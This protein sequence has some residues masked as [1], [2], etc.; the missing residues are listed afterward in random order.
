MTA[1][2]R[3]PPALAACI[4]ALLCLARPAPAQIVIEGRVLD[5]MTE[6]VLAGARVLLL[7][8]FNR[9]A[10]YAVTDA[11]GRFRFERS[12]NERYR[13]E[14]RAVGY[15]ETITPDIWTGDREFAAIEVRLLPNAVLLA[16]LEIVAL[17]PPRTSPVLEAMEFRRTRGFGIQITREAIEQRQPMR[18]TDMLMEIPGVYADRTGTGASARSIRM[19]RALSGP[20]GGPCP[21]QIFLDGMLATRPGAGGDVSVDDLVSPLDVEAIEVFKGLGS[22]PPEFLNVYARCGVIAIW[23]RRSLEGVP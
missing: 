7:N 20:G 17:S 14:V 15:R 9:T 1:L 6:E 12:R 16:P 8:R 23:T 5:D 18:V 4:A 11:Q 19:G 13:V 21:V 22:V 2:S 10:D 3:V